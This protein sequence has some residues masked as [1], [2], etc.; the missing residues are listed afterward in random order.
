MKWLLALSLG[1]LSHLGIAEVRY[2]DDNFKVP[3][4]ADN[5]PK[6][7]IIKRLPLGTKLK[8]LHTDAS[9]GFS[10][11]LWDK[12]SLGWIASEVLTQKEPT[13][14]QLVAAAKRA[15]QSET[16]LTTLRKK[17]TELENVDETI[18]RDRDR[19]RQLTQQLDTQ[20][21]T[22]TKLEGATREMNQINEKLLVKL[23]ATF[24]QLLAVSTQTDAI[25]ESKSRS[26][27]V[28]GALVV[29][30]GFLGGI[31]VT[32]IRWRRDRMWS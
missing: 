16:E 26:W 18:K 31:L 1:F 23:D 7:K 27:F 9:T 13:R 6:H 11:V 14:A 17:V 19:V 32:R 8:L 29:G 4:R 2:I 24:K 28:W 30:A 15:D 20:A 22:I 21:G 12:N 5:G 25:A 3:V 10:N